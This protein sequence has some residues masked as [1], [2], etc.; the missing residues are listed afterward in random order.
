MQLEKIL[1]RKRSLWLLR[2]GP[3]STLIAELS[4]AASFH[5]TIPFMTQIVFGPSTPRHSTLGLMGTIKVLSR[6][7][8]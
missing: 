5:P 8:R 6:G 1:H 7:V 3:S 2:S 4:S